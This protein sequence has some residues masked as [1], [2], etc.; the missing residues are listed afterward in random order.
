MKTVCILGYKF[1]GYEKEIVEELKKKYKIIFIDYDLNLFETLISKFL[2]KI[3]VYLIN[4]KIKKQLKIKDI[5]ILLSISGKEIYFGNMKFLEKEY[6]IK[7]KILYLWDN[8]IRVPNFFEIKQFFDEV[9]TFDF[10]DSKKYNLRYRP[11]F[12]SKRLEEL[13]I[14]DINFL[15]KIDIFFIG[16]YRKNRLEI[17]KNLYKNKENFIYLYYSRIFYYIYKFMRKKDFKNIREYINFSPITREKYNEIFMQSKYIIDIPE[18]NQTGFTQRV[19]DAIF[20]EKKVITTQKNI[21]EESIYNPNNIL[22]IEKYEDIE[23]NKD[24]FKKKY[25]KISKD[26]IEYYSISYW[27]NEILED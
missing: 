12:Y 10:A 7:K 18:E 1:Y 15:K 9:Y 5:D 27:A 2:K 19:L 22:I 16:I 20:L 8:I 6:N 25:K 21:S 26:K 24:F 17:L 14:K 11:T 3:R 13:K 4:K 23:K